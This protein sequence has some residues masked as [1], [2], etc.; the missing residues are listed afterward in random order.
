MVLNLQRSIK[1]SSTKKY[2]AGIALSENSSLSVATVT[3]F[4]NNRYVWQ[5]SPR[6]PTLSEYYSLWVA[7]FTKGTNIH[8][9]KQNSVSITHY[10]R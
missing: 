8:Q 7:I 3:M 9:E 4:G 10:D 5:H 2:S 1:R 6:G